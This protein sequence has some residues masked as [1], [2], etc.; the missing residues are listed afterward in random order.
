MLYEDGPFVR[1]K[2][3]RVTGLRTRLVN[4]I[5]IDQRDG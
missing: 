4:C 1:V 5:S 2:P 3:G